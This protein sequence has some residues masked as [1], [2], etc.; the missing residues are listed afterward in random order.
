MAKEGCPCAQCIKHRTSLKSSFFS[1][2]ARR[3]SVVPHVCCT[4]YSPNVCRTAFLLIGWTVCGLLTY[5]VASAKVENKVYDPFE[6]LG[7]ASVCSA[8]SEVGMV[9]QCFRSRVL[10]QKKSS[11]T[12][13][14]YLGNCTSAQSSYVLSELTTCN[15]HPDKVKLAVNQTMEMVEAHF[16]EITKA[17][18]AYA[19]SIVL[20]MCAVF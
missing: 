1:P 5:K 14:N 10:Q 19:S 17:Y 13:R 2:K 9:Y 20:P 12:T 3:R 6:I 16:V 8:Y 18:K 4:E 7:I 11:H 15:S